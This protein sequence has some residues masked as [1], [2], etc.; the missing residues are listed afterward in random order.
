M[1]LEL[2]DIMILSFIVILKCHDNWNRRE[3]FNIVISPTRYYRKYRDYRKI[4][5]SETFMSVKY[6]QII[7]TN[8]VSVALLSDIMIISIIVIITLMIYRDMKFLLSPIP[9]CYALRKMSAFSISLWYVHFPLDIATVDHLQ[10]IHHIRCI[11][12]SIHLRFHHQ[13][14]VFINMFTCNH[15]TYLTH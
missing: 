8:L 9:R 13:W 12:T 14:M 10:W 15:A 4:H 5:C 7:F 2:G 1:L 6:F 3:I 11:P